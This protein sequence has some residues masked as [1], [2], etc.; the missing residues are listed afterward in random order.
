M[1]K[2]EP[3]GQANRQDDKVDVMLPINIANDPK[4]NVCQEIVEIF[5]EEAVEAIHV[6]IEEVRIFDLRMSHEDRPSSLVARRSIRDHSRHASCPNLH[7]P[8]DPAGGGR[9][10]SFGDEPRLHRL[11]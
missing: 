9:I 2:L 5:E 1:F 3:F 8:I 7:S 4:S 11:M 6:L 10:Q